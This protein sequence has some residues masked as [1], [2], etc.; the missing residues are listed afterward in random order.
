MVDFGV[1]FDI[2][3]AEQTFQFFRHDVIITC[4]IGSN[5][6]EFIVEI[7]F[8]E[9]VEDNGSKILIRMIIFEIFEYKKIGV[10]YEI[11][12]DIMNYDIYKYQ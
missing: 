6:K 3:F 7:E 4:I 2:D 5:I 1:P 10:K 8:F 11:G 12:F 9:D